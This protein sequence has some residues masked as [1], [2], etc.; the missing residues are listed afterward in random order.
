VAKRTL[1]AGALVAI[2]AAVAVALV[3]GGG[4]GGPARRP[5]SQGPRPVG[6][7]APGP[8]REQLGASVNRLFNDRAYTQAQI[9]GQ[10]EALRQTGATIARS[11]A[12]WEVTEPTAPVNGVHR[13]DWRFDDAVAG[14]LAAHG[15]QWLA[16]LDYSAGWAQSVAGAAHSPPHSA[17]DFAAF[18]AAFAS[19]YGARG[20]FWRERPK[21]A[22]EPVGTY[23]VWNEPDGSGFWRP[24]PDA[25]RYVDLYLA[26][27]AAVT[28]VDASARVIVGGLA[29]PDVFLPKMLAARPSLRGRVDGIG[30]H[31]YG[32]DPATVL[33]H[34]RQ[35]HSTIASLG[36]GSVPLYVT[37]FGWTTSPP[38]A[39]NY[40]AAARRPGYIRAT[41]AA[42]GNS[43]CGIAAVLLYTWM[44]PERNPLEGEDW[45]GIAPPRG[46]GSA[47]IVAF[48]QGLRAAS[49]PG[50]VAR[51]C[52]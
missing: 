34:V 7:G 25:A 48:T 6:R 2:A 14:S 3:A 12:L 10:L 5:S 4:T 8:A 21:L 42:L 50:S 46:G 19:R 52:S 9:D 20:T 13:Y 31:P 27:R 23:E 39:T 11:D 40:L 26:A 32:A 18:A 28:A 24:A 45:F 33:A 15:L 51:V 16:I 17:A 44:T 1:T 37:E 47:D 29:H 38:G 43:D 49:Q 30:I 22:V 41:M 36:L 35:A